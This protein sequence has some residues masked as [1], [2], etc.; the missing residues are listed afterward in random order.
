VAAGASAA[1]RG[2]RDRRSA[3]LALQ[4]AAGNRVAGK[5]LARWIKHPDEEQKG[6]VVPDVVAAEYAR[7]NA[8]MNE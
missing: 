1:A 3:A 6:V 4:R 5:V 7:F 2:P 8:P